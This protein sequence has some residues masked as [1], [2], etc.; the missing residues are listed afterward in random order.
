MVKDGFALPMSCFEFAVFWALF[1]D[2]DL[3]VLLA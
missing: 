2:L 3:A 1:G